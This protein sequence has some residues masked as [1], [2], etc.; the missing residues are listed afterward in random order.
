M[1][2]DIIVKCQWLEKKCQ[3][4]QQDNQKLRKRLI[5][6][7]KL[8][9]DR[10]IPSQ[11]YNHEAEYS[12]GVIKDLLKGN[13][14]TYQ[15]LLKI[16]TPQSYTDLQQNILPELVEYF[17]RFVRT[18]KNYLDFLK[19]CTYSGPIFTSISNEYN[20]ALRAK[21]GDV[22]D[23]LKQRR[24]L[25][26]S[27]SWSVNLDNPSRNIRKELLVWLDSADGILRDIDPYL[28]PKNLTKSFVEMDYTDFE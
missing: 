6:L 28:E 8:A 22:R 9:S 13:S 16:P 26:E 3:E 20:L 19:A 18:I 24:S 10:G 23:K 4:Y 15:Q 21:V 7:E 5:R 11:L 25:L 1:N 2:T 17:P 12:N 27:S 14:E